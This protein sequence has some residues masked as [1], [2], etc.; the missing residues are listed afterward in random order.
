MAGASLWDASAF[1]FVLLIFGGPRRASGKGEV[2]PPAGYTP[3]VDSWAFN[4]AAQR[5]RPT[6]KQR[7]TWTNPSLKPPPSE[8]PYRFPP[9]LVMEIVNNSG[10]GRLGPTCEYLSV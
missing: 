7:E 3:I 8:R 9:K 4:L 6:G 2:G 5:F 1:L 10:G